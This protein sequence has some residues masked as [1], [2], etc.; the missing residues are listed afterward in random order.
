M[1]CTINYREGLTGEDVRELASKTVFSP[2]SRRAFLVSGD[3]AFGLARMFEILR[4]AKG[5]FG[6]R[7]FREKEDTLNWV[8]G[9]AKGA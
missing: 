8:L 4:D 2:Q 5:E 6:I 3:L 9:K 1:L 7:V